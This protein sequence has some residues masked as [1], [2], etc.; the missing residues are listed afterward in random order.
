[1][2]PSKAVLAGTFIVNLPVLVIIITGGEVA[3][4]LLNKLMPMQVLSP[5][6]AILTLIL[7]LVSA[8]LM[9]L[10]W[11]ALAWLYW[12]LAVPR[13][14]IWAHRAGADPEKTQILAVRARL[15]WPK[16]SFFERTELPPR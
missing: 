10:V 2:T 8:I 11:A 12:S 3:F 15:V 7:A 9:L 14:R 13:W 1:M 5:A 4:W 6:K 16:G